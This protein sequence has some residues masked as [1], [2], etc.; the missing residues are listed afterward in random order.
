MRRRA[1]EGIESVVPSTNRYYAMRHGTSKAMEQGIIVS[2]LEEGIDPEYGLAD[3]GRQEVL[4][5][6]D[7]SELS[8][9]TLI[10]YSPFSRTLE[11]AVAAERRL[12]ARAVLCAYELVERFFGELD[13]KSTDNYESVWARDRIDSALA[14]RGV[15]PADL[16]AVRG[17]RLVKRLD[18]E[19]DDTT[20]LFVSH[21]DP[22]QILEAVRRGR[23]AGHHR[24]L[25]P[26]APGE[27]RRI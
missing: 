9:D 18:E 17:L 26:L 8:S 19:Y 15:E 5:A 11:S 24:A 13:G 2:S 3:G 7:K 23:P 25:F 10:V 27:I 12:G 4:D 20:V 21:G 1:Y 14:Y 6:I 16:V 22:L